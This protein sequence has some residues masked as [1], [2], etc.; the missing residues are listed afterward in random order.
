VGNSTWKTADH[1]PHKDFP[2][3]VHPT[4]NW[5]KKVKGKLHYFGKVADDPDGTTALTTWLDQKDDLLAGRKPR[6]KSGGLVVYELTQRFLTHKQELLDAGEIVSRTLGEYKATC[7]LLDKQLGSNRLVVD[8]S[9]E[10]FQKLRKHMAKSWGPVRLGNEIQRVRSVFRFATESGLID[11][12]IRFGPGFKKPSA[13]TLRLER[14]NKGERVFKAEQIRA[15]LKSADPHI[16]AMILLAINGGLGNTDLALLTE[17]HFDIEGAWLDYP[18]RKT[19]MARRIPLW[20]ETVEAVKD[21]IANR[22]VP[23]DSTSMLLFVGAR[24]STYVNE[25]GGHRIAHEFERL[26]DDVGIDKERTFY[27]LRRTFETVADNL[28]RDAEGVR[29]IMGHAPRSGDMSA[30]YRQSWFAE[31]LRSIANKVHD[32]LYADDGGK[33][34]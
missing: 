6:G 11:K 34:T 3:S 7:Q 10:D 22:R 12:A 29:A 28:S 1:K 18:R 32:W 9:P 5:C 4:G 30:V 14:A 13:K 25:T 26:R 20:K 21:A 17:K 2:L 8:V 15:L 24:G 27:D 16:K 19:G 33:K 31:R 23:K